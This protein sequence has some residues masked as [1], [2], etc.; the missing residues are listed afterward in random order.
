MEQL[1]PFVCGGISS[2]VAEFG[3]DCECYCRLI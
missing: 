1:K 2:I 3:E